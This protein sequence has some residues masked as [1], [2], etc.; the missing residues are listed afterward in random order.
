MTTDFDKHIPEA[1][2][3]E[4]AMGMLCE[5]DGAFWEEHLL[6]CEVC[7]DR[8]VEADEYIRVVKDAAAAIA[9]PRSGDDFRKRRAL[10]K[11]MMAATHAALLLAFL[12]GWHIM[13]LPR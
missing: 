8:L 7:Q 4:F 3:D 1:I 12:F 9:D 6:L 2:I 10:A 13:F 11:P 5:E